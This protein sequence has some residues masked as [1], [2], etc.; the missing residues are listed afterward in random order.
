MGVP[1]SPVETN[2]RP[3]GNRFCMQGIF[4]HEP[5]RVTSEVGAGFD[6]RF[7][8]VLH[9]G[10]LSTWDAFSLLEIL[11]HD[12][13]EECKTWS[14]ML[15][16]L[17]YFCLQQIKDQT[18]YLIIGRNAFVS[19]STACNYEKGQR[20]IESS[21]KGSSR[22]HCWHISH[23]LHMHDLVWESRRVCGIIIKTCCFWWENVAHS[24]TAELLVWLIM[25]AVIK[26]K[27]YE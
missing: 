14:Q 5:E 18:T 2:V 7:T 21:R 22:L 12:T 24:F 10:R 26:T 6:G 19:L 23:P 25:S 9:S 15:T 27:S 1:V 11:W 17:R 13:L 20:L 3:G 8:R 16:G 4:A